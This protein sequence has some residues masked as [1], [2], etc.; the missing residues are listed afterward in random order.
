MIPRLAM[1]LLISRVSVR[2]E[3]I[4]ISDLHLGYSRG[5][6]SKTCF[7]QVAQD[8]EGGVFG[9]GRGSTESDAPF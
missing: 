1:I 9:S 7:M 4:L 3:T 2:K 6:S 5:F 8:L